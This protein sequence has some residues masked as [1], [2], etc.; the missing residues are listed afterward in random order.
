MNS[1]A[2]VKLIRAWHDKYILDGEISEAD[3]DKALKV[4]EWLLK[5]GLVNEGTWLA[6]IKNLNS[7]F[8]RQ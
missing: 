3:Y 7:A 5:K 4:A 2:P 6:M 8:T 1:I